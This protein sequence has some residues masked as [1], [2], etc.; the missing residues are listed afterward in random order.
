LYI[1]SFES[2]YSINEMKGLKFFIV[3]TIMA[4]DNSIIRSFN[5]MSPFTPEPYYAQTQ[6]YRSRIHDNT[7]ASKTY[8]KY[9]NVSNW[10]WHMS[11]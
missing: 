5:Y 3:W 4:F 11:I 9:N 6:Y 2:L 10:K 8:T 7:K 1:K